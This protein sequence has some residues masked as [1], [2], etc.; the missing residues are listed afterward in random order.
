[1]L[2]DACHAFSDTDDS[3]TAMI[4]EEHPPY[5]LTISQSEHDHVAG[6]PKRSVF[7]V[8]RAEDWDTEGVQVFPVKP[9]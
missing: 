9:V 2:W 5:V 7:G 8:I 1:M 3:C 6:S 4:L